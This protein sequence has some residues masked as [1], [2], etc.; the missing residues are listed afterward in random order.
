[1]NSADISIS[2]YYYRCFVASK[3]GSY[4]RWR[5]CHDRLLVWIILGGQF[6]KFVRLAW[7]SQVSLPPVFCFKHYADSDLLVLAAGSSRLSVSSSTRS[8]A[9]RRLKISS[10]DLA[11][12]GLQIILALGNRPKSE[13]FTYTCSIAIYGFFAAYLIANTVILT[14]KASVSPSL[15]E[16]ACTDALPLQFLCTSRS[17]RDECT[18][19]ILLDSAYQYSARYDERYR[20]VCLLLRNVRSYLRWYRRNFR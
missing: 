9:N 3:S 11:I 10:P 14:I 15:L 19:L 7:R 6:W 1:M 18:K 17:S 16:R 4:Q 12:F 5:S 20:R 2:H 8:L 13:R